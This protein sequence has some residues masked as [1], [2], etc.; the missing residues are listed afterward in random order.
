MAAAYRRCPPRAGMCVVDLRL[1]T[2][3]ENYG[4]S[5]IVA[6]TAPSMQL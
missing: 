6:A 1:G 4:P 2:M 5:T 3:A